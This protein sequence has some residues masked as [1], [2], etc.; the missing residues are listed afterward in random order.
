MEP[1]VKVGMQ[2]TYLGRWFRV[3]TFTDTKV[4]FTDGKV[5]SC[6]DR[7]VFLQLAI[8]KVA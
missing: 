3:L 4:I 8:L 5:R 6:I 1:Q 7:E 2:F